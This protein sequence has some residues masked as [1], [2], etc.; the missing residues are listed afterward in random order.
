MAAWWEINDIGSRGASGQADFDNQDWKMLTNDTW[1]KAEFNDADWKTMKLPQPWKQAGLPDFDGIMWFRK[2]VNI[3]ADWAGKDVTIHL[4]KISESDTTYV[5]GA[6]VGSD[7]NGNNLRRYGVPAKN[8]QAGP[9]TI[10]VRVLSRHNNGGF[11]GGEEMRV[12]RNDAPGTMI[13]LEGDWKYRASTPKEK[14]LHFPESPMAH[15]QWKPGFLFNGIIAPLKPFA[16]RGVAWYQGEN[17]AGS[18][19]HEFYRKALPALIRG[20]REQWSAKPDGSDLS[21][22]VVQLPNYEARSELPQIGEWGWT[23]LREAQSMALKE[24]R[25]AVVTTIDSP[26]SSLHPS[27]KAEV[28][29]RL[30]LAALAVEYKQPVEYSGPVFQKMEPVAGTNKMRIHFTHAKGLKTIDGKPEVQGFSINDRWAKA[31]I[32]GETVL[33][34]RDDVEKPAA[35]RYAWA[36]NPPVNLVN[37]AG[38]PAVPF[39]TDPPVR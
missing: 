9:M 15:E 30:A 17:D 20:W 3:P 2:T 18:R 26:D 10:A 38:L 27:N 24:P 28:G 19:N 5:N 32:E 4:G 1:S 29:K 8:V 7:N 16:M 31:Q 13:L 36:E 12:E 39:R 6:T 35:V 11:S 22:F 14:F 23:L 21:F 33:V 25:T 34:W 37:E